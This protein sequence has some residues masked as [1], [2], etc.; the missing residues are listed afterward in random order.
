[1]LADE[2]LL[3]PIP[4]RVYLD[5]DP[6]FVQLWHAVNGIDMRFDA[7][8]HFVTVGQSI[9]E[10]DCPV[11]TCGRDWLPTLQ[12]VVLEH[13]PF[14]GALVHDAA[15]TVGNWRGYGSIEYEGVFYGQKAHSL[16]QL[17]DLP[18]R[19]S[20]RILLALA[21]HADERPD[22]QALDANHWQ[23][24]D[25]A[26]V[27]ASPSAYHGFV[28][29]SKAELGIAKSGYV[30]SRCGGF[31]DRS[32][33]YLASGRPVVAQDTGFGRHLPTGEGL[34][35]FS[36]TDEAAAALDEVGQDYD[37]HRRAARALA[38]EHFDSDRV[39]SKL[40]ERL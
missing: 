18:G 26:T 22:L 36:T 30:V 8:T 32:A 16:R 25:P 15:T 14:A 3:E 31:S 4:T 23:R 38:E 1:M 5:L 33:C 6:A 17:I 27:T 11:P 20:E 40:L 10:P 13:W 19:T 28:Q 37:R 39:L 21:I 35:S 7:H 34:L 9:G 2:R 29:G 24:V 12:P